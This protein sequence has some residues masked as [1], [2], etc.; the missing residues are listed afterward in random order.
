MK[1]EVTREEKE[2][3]DR[4]KLLVNQPVVRY[5][6]ITWLVITTLRNLPGGIYESTEQ[7]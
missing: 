7:D 3:L 2:L 4:L 1:Y 5:P 6:H